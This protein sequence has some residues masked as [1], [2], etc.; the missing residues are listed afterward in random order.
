MSKIGVL[1]FHRCI[2]FGSYWQARALVEGLR[3]RGH[4][5]VVLDHRCDWASRREARCAFQ[6]LLPARST[7]DDMKKYGRKVR[8]VLAAVNE[9]PSSRPFALERPETMDECDTVVVGSDEVW[10]L[11]HPWLGGR[12]AFFGE[13]VR[14]QRVISYA[15]SFGNQDARHGLPEEWAERLERFDAR[16][17]RD[18]NSRTLLREVLDEDTDLVLDPVLQFPASTLADL[19]DN[20]GMPPYLA[21]YG[22]SFPQSYAA[23]VRQYARTAGLRLVSIGYRND[24]AD[25]QRL[26]VG[27]AEFSQ[28]IAHSEAVATNFFHGCVFA[29]LHR[30]PFAA[31]ASEYR[32]NKLRDLVRTL[33]CEDRLVS[34]EPSCEQILRLLSEPL[35]SSIERA[36]TR[37]RAQSD[38]YLDRALA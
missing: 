30:R 28:L 35:G 19:G 37:R 27:P 34:S 36:I 15:A 1:T 8:K 9:L 5:A 3:G 20:P 7:G 17:V 11:C 16:S 24:W 23:A 32:A 22:H 25:A 29:L 6:P 31:V 10:N 13:G 2:N 18:D 14:A 33:A 12:K 21:I 26:D 38:R 4:E